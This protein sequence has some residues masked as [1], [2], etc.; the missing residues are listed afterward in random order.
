MSNEKVKAIIRLLVQVILMINMMLMLAGKNPI[1]F[2]ES[3]VTEFLTTALTGASTVWV[4]WKNNNMT[5]EAAY[6]Q[7]TLKVLKTNFVDDG[8]QEV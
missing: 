2:N 1:P 8:E 7:K 6:A 4:W 5:K 3:V